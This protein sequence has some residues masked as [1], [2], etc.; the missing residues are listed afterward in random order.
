[1]SASKVTTP[2]KGEHV[3]DSQHEGVFEVVYVNELMQTANIRLL[4]GTG[5]VVPNVPW[6]ALEGCG[7][8]VNRPSRCQPQYKT[9]AALSRANSLAGEGKGGT[10]N[11]TMYE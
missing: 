5:H 9:Q 1:M 11:S 2:K 3:R 10:W 6:A 8:R 7:Q 4:D